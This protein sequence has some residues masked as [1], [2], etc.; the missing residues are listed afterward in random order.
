MQSILGWDHLQVLAG[1]ECGPDP[2]IDVFGDILD[3]AVGEDDLGSAVMV[4]AETQLLF[5]HVDIVA[6]QSIDRRGGRPEGFAHLV[7]RDA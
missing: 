3:V 4:A 6:E 1:A 2:T 7:V 5:I